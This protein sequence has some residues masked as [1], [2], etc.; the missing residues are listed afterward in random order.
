[1]LCGC[2][3]TIHREWS[4]SAKAAAV[5]I[6]DADAV[7]ETY[8][9]KGQCADHAAF[10]A[11][12]ELYA[13]IKHLHG[14]KWT[15]DTCLAPGEEGEI[16]EG[17]NAIDALHSRGACS[18][19]YWWDDRE[20]S[21]VRTHNPVDHPVHTKRCKHHAHLDD[22]EDHHATIL[23]ENQ[24]KNI[25]VNAIAEHLNMP[26]QMVPYAYEV[27]SDKSRSVVIDHEALGVSASVVASVMKT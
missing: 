25:A 15:P 5:G 1:M 10:S 22:H 21:D 26:P 6:T 27:Q 12:D 8:T 7:T 19:F 3:I 13:E 14:T 17:V 11:A 16:P 23:A 2:V 9:I 24:A 20:P 4:V 18:V